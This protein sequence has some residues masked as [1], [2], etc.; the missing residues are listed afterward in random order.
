[1]PDHFG[2]NGFKRPLK[3]LHDDKTINVSDI[4]RMVND[5]DIASTDKKYII[6]LAAMGYDKLLGSGKVTYALEIKVAKSSKSAM[7]K[8]ENAGGK[9]VVLEEQTVAPVSK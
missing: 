4:N 6:D 3:M 1:M 9:V 8:V 5:G 7:E 2:R